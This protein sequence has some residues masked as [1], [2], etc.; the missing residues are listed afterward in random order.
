MKLAA[1]RPKV[2]PI[3]SKPERIAMALEREI[4]SGKL[5]LGARLNS[6]AELVRR[7]SVSRATV[8]KSLEALAEKGLIQTKMG[9]GSFVSFDG[10]VLDNAQGWT[11]AISQ[12]RGDVETRVLRIEI[13]DDKALADSLKQQLTRFIAVDR[14]RFLKDTGRVVSVERSRVPCVPELEE[15]PLKG[16]ASGSLQE[17]MRGAGLIAENGEEWVA[18]EF[19][20]VADAA[21]MQAPEGSP[22]LR[23]TRIVRDETGRAIEYV[24]SLLDPKLFALHLEF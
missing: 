4:R 13:I 8:R 24:I 3:R 21:I 22:V 12:H 20:S 7:F 6:E 2:D 16:L 17:T 15:A 5:V 9:I 18:V 11:R 1:V 23:T 19:L 10:Q 14:I